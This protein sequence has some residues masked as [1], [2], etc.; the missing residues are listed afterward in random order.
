MKAL[1]DITREISKKFSSLATLSSRALTEGERALA[2]SVFGDAL[3]LDSIR[4]CSSP[5]I[6]KGYA[7]SP[8]GSV[9]FNPKDL[10]DDFSKL[11][12]P[13]QSW[14]IHEFVHVWQMQ[15]G[16]KVVRHAL[17]DR[18]YRYILEEGKAFFQYGLE[19]QA[20]MV[21]DYF[22]KRERGEACSDLKACL[23]FG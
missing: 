4:I 22:L 12:L 13:T 3:K 8:N 20:K 15:Q 9:Y 21:E 19:Q 10:S 23:P 18:R 6:L 5:L 14:L 1:A 17:F 7:M 2:K 16:I 11:S